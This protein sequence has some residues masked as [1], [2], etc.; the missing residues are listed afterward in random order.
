MSTVS[1]SSTH[2]AAFRILTDI[3]ADLSKREVAFPTFANATVKI[4]KALDDPNT[5]SEALARVISSEPLLSAKLVHV[6]NSAAVNPGGK[7]VNDVKTAVTRV[8][9]NTVRSVAAAVAMTQLSAAEDIRKHAQ[10]ASAVWH[11]SMHVAALSFVI[12]KKMTRQNPD[13]ALFAGLIHDIGYFYLLSKSGSYPEL[14]AEPAAL[15]DVLR[16]WHAPIG[17]AVLHAFTLPEATLTA[18]AEHENGHYQWPPRTIIDVV[19]L[20]NMYAAKTNPIYLH[21]GATVPD[22][23]Q[24]PELVKVLV[25]SNDEI[26]SLVA[27]LNR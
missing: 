20:A 1:P 19:T 15:D 8:G 18:V 13:E 25:D 6:A 21:A 17:Q 9:F 10:R 11:H 3:A 16:D 14:D 7:P 4:R 5:D 12:A 22:T 26:R 24:E 2:Q 23:P 27:A